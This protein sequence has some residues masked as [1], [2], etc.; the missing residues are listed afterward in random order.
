MTIPPCVYIVNRYYLIPRF[1]M[2]GSSREAASVT[3]L[4]FS[5]PPR[6]TS[7]AVWSR[8][9]KKSLRTER[10]IIRLKRNRRCCAGLWLCWLAT[11]FS[12]Y[13]EHAVCLFDRPWS[14]DALTGL[15]LL[16]SISFSAVLMAVCHNW[17]SWHQH[18]CDLLH[19]SVEVTVGC[20]LHRYPLKWSL[21]ALCTDI[22]AIVHFG[23]LFPDVLITLASLVR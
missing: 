17:V 19:I 23:G 2:I 15:L 6:C 1:N 13:S 16:S 14:W 5:V 9:W 4:E 8:S 7:S 18:F 3:W 20:P 11:K 12:H 21:G 22:L 10:V